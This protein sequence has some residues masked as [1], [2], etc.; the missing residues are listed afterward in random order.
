MYKGFEI[1]DVDTS[2]FGGLYGRYKEKGEELMEQLSFGI[3]SD[4]ES[5]VLKDSVL[6]GNMIM[7]NWFKKVDADVFISHSHDD[8]PLAL[9]LSGYLNEKLGIKCFVDSL[10]WGKADKLLA[11][12]D[13]KY[14]R[15]DPD[16]GNYNYC[17]RNYSTSHV[18]NMLLM[19]ITHMIDETDCLFFLNTPNSMPLEDGI[20]KQTLSPWIYSEIEI[21]RVIRKKLNKASEIRCFSASDTRIVE[22]IFESQSLEQLH[23]GYELNIDHLLSIPIDY[24]KRIVRFNDLTTEDRYAFLNFLYTKHKNYIQ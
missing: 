24:I 12:I 3:I 20:K 7:D 10:I 22:P 9:A 19:S 2:S 4:I 5:I 14:S 8:L 15:N 16:N 23:V 17:K 1:K 6:D 13:K 18:H 21:S 11:N